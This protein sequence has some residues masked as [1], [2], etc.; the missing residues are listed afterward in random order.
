MLHIQDLAQA[1]TL[2]EREP[3]RN[4]SEEILEK[5]FLSWMSPELGTNDYQK[6]LNSY[7]WEKKDVKNRLLSS[8]PSAEAS[9]SWVN[10]LNDMNNTSRDYWELPGPFQFGVQSLEN[11]PFN[12]FFLSF[13]SYFEE[14][15]NKLEKFY[16]N[17]FSIAPIAKLDILRKFT[18]DLLELCA[19]TLIAECCLRKSSYSSFVQDLKSTDFREE[20]FRKYPVL[21]RKISEISNSFLKS[22][23]FILR[24]IEDDLPDLQK[25]NM[26]PTN[27]KHIIDSFQLGLGDRHEGNRAV[28]TLTIDGKPI[29]YRP[30]TAPEFEIYRDFLHASSL[31]NYLISPSVLNRNDH[32]WVEYIIHCSKEEISLTDHFYKMG[33]LAG[34]AYALG[35]TDLHMEN[36]VA[37]PSGPVPI[38]LETILSSTL[39]KTSDKA[40]QQAKDYLNDSP[41]GTGILPVNV[42]IS[43]STDMEVSALMGGVLVTTGEYE[44]IVIEA[45]SIKI[46]KSKG[47]T[48]ATRNIPKN[49]SVHDIL[50]NKKIVLRGFDY[51]IEMIAKYCEELSL[52][53][54]KYENQN[55]RV[56]PRPTS[57]YDLM[58]RSLNHPKFMTSMLSTEKFLLSLWKTDGDSSSEQAISLQAKSESRSLVHGDIPRFEVKINDTH[59]KYDGIISQALTDSPI[60]R[61][62]KRI[63]KF[64]EPLYIQ[65][66]RSLIEEVLNAS[67]APNSLADIPVSKPSDLISSPDIKINDQ[68]LKEILHKISQKFLDS[69]FVSSKEATWIGMVSSESS[70]SVRLSPLGTG[71]FDGLA[72]I[73]IALMQCSTVLKD[74]ASAIYAKKA[75]YPVARDLSKWNL[76]TEGPVGAFGGSS[77]LAYALAMGAL[78]LD[79]SSEDYLQILFDFVKKV[80]KSLDKIISMTWGQVQQV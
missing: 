39:K 35:S 59:I 71:L 30:R 16:I 60:G 69:A 28:S 2:S 63:T 24:D 65:Q 26:I 25:Y 18:N 46:K 77:G 42:S 38:D 58:R 17:S 44:E 80:E 56:I 5:A 53:I 70:E 20:I 75:L 52:L 41:L 32:A 64:R 73:S 33:I 1:L 13:V 55:V 7:R 74:E 51:A 10:H 78:Y 76:N 50:D 14:K 48:G 45:D 22:I 47:K 36:I 62:Q 31:S 54:K 9:I 8:A 3:V 67:F 43:G 72:G 79:S 29:V 49:L 11:L 66:Q 37:S 6:Y 27:Q 68:M 15:L 19:P 40:S 57:L 4:F 21:G 61:S 23:E 34:V 12:S